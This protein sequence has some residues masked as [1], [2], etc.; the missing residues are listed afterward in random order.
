MVVLG[1]GLAIVA[2]VLIV[3]FCEP[4]GRLWGTG[5]DARSYWAPSLADPYANADWTTPS[6]YPY[7]PV[8]LQV[9]QPIRVLSWQAFMAVWAA[10]LIGAVAW[11]TGPRLLAAGILFAAMELAGGNIE[12][13]LALAIVLGFRWPSAWTFVLLTK[14][15]PGV[16]LLWFVVRREWRPLAIALASTAAVAAVSILLAPNAWAQWPGVLLAIAG[17]G[18]T[19]AAVP[20]PFVVRLPFAIALVVW[21]A[22]TD[23]RWTVPVAG[24]LALP[25]LWYGGFSMLLAVIPLLPVRTLGDLAA[26]VRDGWH[27][28]TGRS[29]RPGTGVSAG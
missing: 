13:L 25:A 11:L 9:L 26:R 1:V 24:M 4:F 22:R 16:G 12:L 29:D 15:T 14:V 28:V 18:G 2:W 17:R 10:I 6:A 21:G 5:Q 3:A 27:A 19:W 8:L 20:I 7:A 23:R